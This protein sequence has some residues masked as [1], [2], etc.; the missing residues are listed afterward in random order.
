MQN[1]DD[2]GLL[3]QIITVSQIAASDLIAAPHQHW[4]AD[5][6]SI[7]IIAAPGPRNINTTLILHQLPHCH[8]ISMTPPPTQAMLLQFSAITGIA[9][10]S[11]ASFLQH[12][13]SHSFSRC[14]HGSSVTDADR[15][16]TLQLEAAWKAVIAAFS[17]RS[18]L[19][20]SQ[21]S[22]DEL[23]LQPMAT[24][25]KYG[26]QAMRDMT[27]EFWGNSGIGSVLSAFDVSIVES[28]LAPPEHPSNLVSPQLNNMFKLEMWHRD[29]VKALSVLLV[30]DRTPHKTYC[31]HC[32]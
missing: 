28:A 10:A 4:G 27:Q 12:R 18:M 19:Q 22:I 9:T 5:V 2:C 24:A 14:A 20:L 23:F 3:Q 16:T 31:L 29:C 6:A 17:P 21:V 32:C 26:S 13:K 11:T 8:C 30:A 25:L 1:S 15:R 7:T